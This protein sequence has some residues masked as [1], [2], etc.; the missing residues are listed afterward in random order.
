MKKES[1][2]HSHSSI[3]LME[4]IIAIL[5]FAIVSAISLNIF[6]Y[7]HKLSQ[8][9]GN[10]NFAISQS[11]TAAE[12][13]R[14]ADTTEDACQLLVTLMGATKENENYLI[15]YDK[16]YLRCDSSQAAC[17]LTITPAGTVDSLCTWMIQAATM[18]NEIIY[19]LSL[20]VY[21]GY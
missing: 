21:D 14:S 9:T 8:K 7:S 15:Y 16:D 2:T 20:E 19:E 13:V 4:I 5:F 12:I 17:F 11:S 18:D 3:F 10:L 6:V 1:Y